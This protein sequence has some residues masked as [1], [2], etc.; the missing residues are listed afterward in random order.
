MRRELTARPLFA[1]I[2]DDAAQIPF[3]RQP[4]GGQL[5]LQH[6]RLRE[7]L[8]DALHRRQIVR[9]EKFGLK[10]QLCLGRAVR[11]RRRQNVPEHFQLHG[12]APF[13]SLLLG[14]CMR[15]GRAV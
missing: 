12:D 5:L 10:G 3:Q 4:P 7:A 11:T 2:I 6:H 1:L 14:K 15:A 9:D 13:L 8:D